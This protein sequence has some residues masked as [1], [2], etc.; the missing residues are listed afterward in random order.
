MC[1]NT[2]YLLGDGGRDAA[3]QVVLAV[4]NDNL[5]KHGTKF[6]FVGGKGEHDGGA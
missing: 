5:L 4:N 1:F 3:D 6:L 2:T